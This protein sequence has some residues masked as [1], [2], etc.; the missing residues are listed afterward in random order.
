MDSQLH[1]KLAELHAELEQTQVLDDEARQLLGHLQ[2]DIQAVLKE[3]NPST[4]KSL[5]ERLSAAVGHFEESHP[6]LTLMLKQVLDS[7]AQV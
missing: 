6:S 4:R 5:R 3:S 7:L 1:Q 2:R